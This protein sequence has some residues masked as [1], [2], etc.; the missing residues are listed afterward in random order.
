MKVEPG[1]GRPP[2]PEFLGINLVCKQG[3]RFQEDFGIND[4]REVECPE[5]GERVLVK[6]VDKKV[7]IEEV[8]V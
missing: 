8:N 6:V 1:K 2:F 4:E 5:C 3:H 7:T